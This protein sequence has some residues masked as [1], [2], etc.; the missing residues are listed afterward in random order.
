MNEKIAVVLDTNFIITYCKNFGNL[1][2]KLSETYDVYISQVS[3]QEHISQ[4]YLE[5]KEKYIKLEKSINE[6][7]DIADIVIK[8]PFD[9]KFKSLEKT[10]QKYY[11]DLFGENIIPLNTN[12]DTLSILMDRVYKKIPPF[13]T[14]ENASDKGFKDTLIWLSLL[15]YFKENGNSNVFLIT[16]D[17]GF[18]NNL[19]AL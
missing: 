13:S 10:F 15:K 8:K 9:E 11:R 5:L 3:I 14:A 18:R 7:S 2:Q 16:S 12:N 19:D 1:F 4:R 6:Y 17:K